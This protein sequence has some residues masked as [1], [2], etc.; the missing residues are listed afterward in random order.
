MLL[1]PQ[2]EPALLYHPTNDPR[3]SQGGFG[4]AALQAPTQGYKNQASST[5]T[6]TN[7]GLIAPSV[8][9]C[10]AHALSAAAIVSDQ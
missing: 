7:S 2:T 1:T 8:S 4:A 6:T 9:P 10:V 5:Y 3:Y